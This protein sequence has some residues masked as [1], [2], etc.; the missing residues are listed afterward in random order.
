MKSNDQRYFSTGRTVTDKIR[1]SHK[2]LS[3][4]WQGISLFSNFKD[5]VTV[6]GSV[7]FKEEHPYYQIARSMGKALAQNGFAVMTGGGPG[8]AQFLTRCRNPVNRTKRT[9]IKDNYSGQII[10]L[11]S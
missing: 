4:H 3:D 5:C 6:Y 2:A 10:N 1:D 7:R 11:R 8:R 9:K